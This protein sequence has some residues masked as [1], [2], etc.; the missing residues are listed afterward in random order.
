M[1]NDESL[2][3]LHR[4]LIALGGALKRGILG[5]S[6]HDYMKQFT[7]SDEYWDR[8]TAARLGW[9]QKQPLKPDS[10]RFRSSGDAVVHARPSVRGNAPCPPEPDYEPV[11][12]WTKRQC[13]DYLARNPGY[14]STYEAELQ[15]RGDAVASGVNGASFDRLGRRR[16]NRDKAAS[17]TEANGAKQARESQTDPL[18]GL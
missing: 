15:K 9:P 11:H 1:T 18:C 4:M 16:I 3:F 7:D 10:D 6:T 17:N 8:V 5:K 13:D 2:G 14:R 12:A